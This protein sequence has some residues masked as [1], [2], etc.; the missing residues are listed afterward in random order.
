L[1]KRTIENPATNHATTYIHA[2]FSLPGFSLVGGFFADSSLTGF[3]ILLIVILLI[4]TVGIRKQK[5]LEESMLE[6]AP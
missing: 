2:G 4:V 3:C 5:R 6:D 1:L